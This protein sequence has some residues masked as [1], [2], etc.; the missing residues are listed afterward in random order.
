MPVI[1]QNKPV[2][3]DTEIRNGRLMWIPAT[4]REYRLRRRYMLKEKGL[5]TRHMR[6]LKRRSTKNRPM[7]SQDEVTP[8]HRDIYNEIERTLRHI[9]NRIQ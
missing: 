7:L 4:V 9:A 5:Q 6:D 3:R 8:T 1:C 2:Q